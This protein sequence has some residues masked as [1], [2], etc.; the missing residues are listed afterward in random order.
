LKLAGCLHDYSIKNFFRTT[1]E[2]TNIYKRE[3]KYLCVAQT[4]FKYYH[5]YFAVLEVI[6]SLFNYFGDTGVVTQ[7]FMIAR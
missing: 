7:G 4:S 5:R 1:L 2:I 6:L 3:L